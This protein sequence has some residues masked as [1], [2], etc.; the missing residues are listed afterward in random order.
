MKRK[1]SMLI[2]PVLI[3]YLIVF[4]GIWTIWEFW[5]KSFISNTVE[6]E[7]ISQVIKSGVIKNLVWTFPAILL[8]QH[9]KSEVHITLKEMFST[10]VNLLK[11]LPVFIFFTVYVLAGSILQ[12]GKVEI[13]RD[14]GFDK[15]IIVLFVGLTEEMVFRGWLLNATIRENKKWFYIIINAVMFLA[16]HFPKWI[17]NGTFFSSFAS[18]QFL[19]VMVLSIIFSC[20]FIKSRNILVPITLHMYFDLL[21]F[22]F[23]C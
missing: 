4:Y 20:T 6:N 12:N 22:M 13:V 3:V 2:L 8:V 15:I 7:C 16:I 23:I 1:N 5:L 11:Y 14:F 9:F 19:E 21:V 18:F 10:K 17:H